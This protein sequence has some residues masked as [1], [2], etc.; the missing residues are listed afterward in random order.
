MSQSV[1]DLAAA[2][3]KRQ[4]LNQTQ[5]NRFGNLEALLELAIY[6]RGCIASSLSSSRVTVAFVLERV[7]NKCAKDL[8]GRPVRISEIADL[9]GRL[10]P[11]V[12]R[13]VDFLAGAED[14]PIEVAAALI[15]AHPAER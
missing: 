4:F 12:E 2:H 9:G 8:D 11:P 1:V 14:D 7:L 3:L 5:R 13:A 10:Q 6:A 15:R